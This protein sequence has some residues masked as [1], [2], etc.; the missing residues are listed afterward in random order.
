VIGSDPDNGDTTFSNQDIITF[1]FDMATYIGRQGSVGS[2]DPYR[3]RDEGGGTVL[4]QV[5]VN[6][7]FR[8][9]YY[10]PNQA[11]SRVPSLGLDYTGRWTDDSTFVIT[12]VNSVRR[13]GRDDQN[14]IW[15]RMPILTDES[16]MVNNYMGV[17]AV[18]V[19][20]LGDVR[21]LGLQSPRCTDRVPLVGTWGSRTQ[22]PIVTQFY[23]TD[24]DNSDSIP[25]AGD[26]LTI[27][28]DRRTSMGRTARPPPPDPGTKAYADFFMEF[29]PTIGPQY[30]AR[31]TDDST[32]VL[33]VIEGDPEYEL[34]IIRIKPQAQ[35]KNGA[36]SSD[37]ANREWDLNTHNPT[38]WG[39]PGP[40]ALLSGIVSDYDNFNTR[41][42]GEDTLRLTFDRST[43]DGNRQASGG[44][45]Y[46]DQ[47]F[48]FDHWLGDDYSGEWSDPSTFTITA[49]DTSV[50]RPEIGRTS[51][52][53]SRAILNTAAT[54]LGVE[55]R[56]SITGNFGAA[57]FA[58]EL[59]EYVAMDPMVVTAGAA[60]GDKCQIRFNMNTDRGAGRPL[61]QLFT[62]HPPLPLDAGVRWLDG[63][64]FEVLVGT[65]GA[66]PDG[67]AL[68]VGA[69][70]VTVHAGVIRSL[71]VAQANQNQP[72]ALETYAAETNL[73]LGGS[74]GSADPPR[75]I[76]FI[77]ADPL[78]SDM[79]YGD[80]DALIITF[81]VYTTESGPLPNSMSVDGIM[82]FSNLLGTDY[83]GQW[84]DCND[85][86][87]MRNCRTLTITIVDSRI[88][89]MDF[90]GAAFTQ[91]EIGRTLAW[92]RAPDRNNPNQPNFWGGV[93]SASEISTYSTS[94]VTL[95]TSLLSEG[96]PM[97]PVL[98]LG[99]HRLLFLQRVAREAG[100]KGHTLPPALFRERQH[101]FD[102]A[103][104]AAAATAEGITN[105]GNLEERYRRH[106]YG[107]ASSFAIRQCSLSQQAEPQDLEMVGGLTLRVGSCNFTTGALRPVHVTAGNLNGGGCGKGGAGCGMTLQL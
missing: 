22:M 40:P 70:Q 107:A 99:Q 77:S 52:V 24:P 43:D 42:S 46:I 2:L 97:H 96:E 12:I 7:L 28:F 56:A 68:L 47:I 66:G 31:F 8:F 73:T 11:Q 61:N 44:R 45:E 30:T 27:V 85:Q 64:T 1:K 49:I 72:S 93:R 89:E 18:W 26:T 33:T 62:F 67:T 76:S 91:P 106:P 34:G 6:A 48:A 84:S 88:P 23:G 87:Q 101:A 14:R 20:V 95:G 9:D 75:I 60:P 29:V 78:G 59:K 94:V 58:P 71:R 39:K 15:N 103:A 81:D 104:T 17:D 10:Q 38:F 5:G 3:P 4:T 35:I 19:E 57:N 86:V 54:A 16:Y 41:W 105:A 102:A 92:V 79:L 32:F 100:G 90:A 55:R 25:S 21:S 82:G 74:F 51:I 53:S 13:V 80:G 50:Q 69:S 36:A 63:S 37:P 83:T 98:D 65:S